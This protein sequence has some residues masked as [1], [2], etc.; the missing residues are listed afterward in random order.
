VSNESCARWCG[1]PRGTSASRPHGF[2]RFNLQNVQEQQCGTSRPSPLHWSYHVFSMSPDSPQGPVRLMRGVPCGGCGCARSRSSCRCQPPAWWGR[3]SS[4]ASPGCV[5]RGLS[6][7]HRPS[8]SWRRMVPLRNIAA[9]EAT[10]SLPLQ[11][12]TGWHNASG[13]G[14]KSQGLPHHKRRDRWKSDTV[15]LNERTV[16][17]KRI[18][19]KWTPMRPPQ[20][21]PG[22]AHGRGG[23]LTAR[24]AF[25]RRPWRPSP[26]AR[27]TRRPARVGSGGYHGGRRAALG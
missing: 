21:P 20:G 14:E 24:R 7:Q 3:G 25:R 6:L 27:R 16:Y 12:G 23:G 8:G 1:T 10:P 11:A 5:Y 18:P 17:N 26:R 4:P 19:M 22:G 2:E 9:L 13:S 15:L